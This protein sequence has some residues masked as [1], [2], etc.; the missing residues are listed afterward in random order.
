MSDN[1]IEKILKKLSKYGFKAT[2]DSYPFSGAEGAHITGNFSF[3]S[4][5]RTNLK[6]RRIEDAVFSSAAVTGSYFEKC[7]FK[8]CKLD[9]ADYEYCN[10]KE[11]DFHLVPLD[12]ISFN[13]SFF[14]K[15]NFWESPFLSCTLTGTYF[16][17]TLFK[18]MT[19]EHCTLEGSLFEECTFDNTN[20]LNLN[21]EYAQ[22]KNMRFYNAKLPFS[23][24]PYIF[25]GITCLTDPSNDISISADNKTFLSPQEYIENGIPLLCEYYQEIKAHFPLANI[26]IGLNQYSKAYK[27]LK[28]GM[29]Q[30]VITKDFRMLKYYCKLAVL[31]NK[32]SYKDLNSMYQLIQ[33]YFS[34][35][36][37]SEQQLY[38]YSKHIGEIKT[39]L[40]SKIDEPEMSFTIKTN[41]EPDCFKTLSSILSDIFDFK[42]QLCSKNHASKVI[43]GE[44][45]PFI[46][47]VDISDDYLNLY[48][49]ALVLI[50]LSEGKCNLYE[51]YVLQLS[52]HVEHVKLIASGITNTLNSLLVKAEERHQYYVQNQIVLNVDEMLFSNISKDLKLPLQYF[53]TKEQTLIQGR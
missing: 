39:L 15:C 30:S 6:D 41:I 44:N 25:G 3:E 9:N 7:D 12:G 27:E 52:E 35:D 21:F 46:I 23:Q 16:T 14:L 45:S 19:I 37:L 51:S 36:T 18:N 42:S 47:T 29:Q 32:F 20:M 50:V 31:S 4:V 43:L 53:N 38:N 13:N 5:K 11:C 17:Q 33:K 26:Y 1:K 8:T 34:M 2:N 24:L 40:L 48:L 49:F 10:F 28:L 22:F